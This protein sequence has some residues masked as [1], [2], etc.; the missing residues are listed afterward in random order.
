MR[1]LLTSAGLLVAAGLRPSTRRYAKKIFRGPETPTR[2]TREAN[3]AL[4]EAGDLLNKGDGEAA[5][6]ALVMHADALLACDGATL[7]ALCGD[8]AAL[9]LRP[10]WGKAHGRRAAVV[11]AASGTLSSLTAG[12]GPIAGRSPFIAP[13]FCCV[14]TVILF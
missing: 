10:D 14:S 2:E 7:S 6:H 1:R 11:F 12:K 4:A 13:I 5:I 8:D 9:A 3:A